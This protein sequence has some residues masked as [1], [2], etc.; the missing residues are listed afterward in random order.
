MSATGSTYGR[1]KN[2]YNILVGKHELKRP[3]ERTRRIWE[4]NIRIYPREI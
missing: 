3:L 2:T 4:G 1:D